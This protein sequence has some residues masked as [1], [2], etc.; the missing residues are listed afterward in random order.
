MNGFPAQATTNDGEGGQGERSPEA[1]R[2][3]AGDE[4]AG[5]RSAGDVGD[6]QDARVVFRCLRCKSEG[7]RRD[8]LLAEMANVSH[9]ALHGYG[10]RVAFFA[11][12][13]EERTPKD[14]R[15]EGH[16]EV[17]YRLLTVLERASASVA[18]RVEKLS[19]TELGWGALRREAYFE[20]LLE[21]VWAYSADRFVHLDATLR[22][23]VDLPNLPDQGPEEHLRPRIRVIDMDGS[24]FRRLAG[25]DAQDY[26]WLWLYNVLVVSCFLK[27]ALDDSREFRR[28]W[29]DKIRAA[30][31]HVAS[32]RDAPPGPGHT[33]VTQ[34]RWDTEA[35]AAALRR[36]F[37]PG[38]EP[39][40]CGDTPEAAARTA[41]PKAA[42]FL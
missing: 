21:T 36:A 39:P 9:A 15:E 16:T 19:G 38:D 34:A 14:A 28:V 6:E 30:V 10:L 2:Y 32:R 4:G 18:Q 23:F 5:G 37:E 7:V 29:W 27:V 33:F 26:L 22:N 42:S 12:T 3:R 40:W 11:W 1:P 20:Q 13:R 41:A 25:G 8:A 17:S 35:C 24:V 31:H